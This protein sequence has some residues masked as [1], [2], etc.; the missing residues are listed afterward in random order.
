MVL[1]F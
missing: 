1:D